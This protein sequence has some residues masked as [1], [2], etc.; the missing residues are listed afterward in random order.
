MLTGNLTAIEAVAKVFEGLE[1]MFGI[2]FIIPEQSQFATVIGAALCD[3][4]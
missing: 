3:R 1:A 2:E 4:D